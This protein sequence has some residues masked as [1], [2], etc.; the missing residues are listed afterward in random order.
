MKKPNNGSRI[1]PSCYIHPTALVIGEVEIGPNCSLWPYSV[2]RGDEETIRI[3]RETNIQDS[4]VV[5][6]DLEF[7]TSIGDQVTVGHGAII[8]GSTIGNRCI[9]GIR[10]TVLDGCTVG[11]GCIIGAGAVLTP[12]TK[13]PKNSMVLGIPGTIKRNDPAF[14]MMALK[15]AQ[16]YVELSRRYID[17]QFV[18]RG[19]P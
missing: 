17:G 3:G 7:P 6:V 4:A 10:S 2:I 5:H 11:D 12:G 1:D 15:N 13:V 8:H 19:I 16:V 18:A 14:E 9:I